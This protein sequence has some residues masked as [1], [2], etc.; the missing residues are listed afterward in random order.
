MNNKS[1]IGIRGVHRMTCLSILNSGI[2][3]PDQ[4][5]PPPSRDGALCGSIHGFVGKKTEDPQAM[6]LLIAASE[7]ATAA[8]CRLGQDATGPA[9]ALPQII[10]RYVD[11]VF[12][13]EVHF[14]FPNLSAEK[15]NLLVAIMKVRNSISAILN[16]AP[17]RGSVSEKVAL[18]HLT[19]DLQQKFLEFRSQI[20][21]S[22]LNEQLDPVQKKVFQ[23]EFFSITLDKRC[24]T[25]LFFSTDAAPRS[26]YV[27][28]GVEAP[29]LTVPSDSSF[30]R[31][32]HDPIAPFSPPPEAE[33][34]EPHV[35]M[36]SQS[37]QPLIDQ[38][39]VAALR[40]D[41]APQPTKDSPQEP[42]FTPHLAEKRVERRKTVLLI[43]ADSRAQDLIGGA[44]Q[45]AGHSLLMANAGFTGYANA[46]RER[47]DLVL[48]D[49]GLSLEV[50]GPDA[51]L[52][53][54][55]VLKMLSQLPS[56]R[57]LPFIGL[58]SEG[59]SE[60][61][62]QVLALGARACLQKPLDPGRVLD[63]VQHVWADRP[64]EPEEATRSPWNVSASV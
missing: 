48:V 19:A 58:V 54:R 64:S 38:P 29:E 61:E 33:V 26:S 47:P 40:P 23:D 22:G 60:I 11:R 8:M 1:E 27:S 7:Y 31:S 39:V 43:S 59:T 17:L 6:K 15:R 55:G 16:G 2:V 24:S 4:A 35:R 32:P 56:N 44:M 13:L 57:S 51:C 52:D 46:M 9:T 14:L 42:E 62:S 21:A 12:D 20:V 28:G 3:N 30:R 5:A 45:Q 25:T 50:S 34:L 63:A 18:E 10:D 53:G 49:L 41:V 37:T 36:Q